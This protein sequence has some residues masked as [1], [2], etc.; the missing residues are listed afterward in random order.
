MNLP[1]ILFPGPVA[2]TVSSLQLYGE[3]FLRLFFPAFCGTCPVLLGAAE[4]G[5]CPSCLARLRESRFSLDE[6]ILSR[7]FQSLDQGWAAYPYEFPVKDLIG[8]VKFSGKRSLLK[9]FRE[10]LRTL[11]RA[12]LAENHYDAL[13]PIPI[14]L[15]KLLER[16]YN[17]SELIAALIRREVSIPV[18]TRTLRKHHRTPS[19]G[20]LSREERKTNLH[21]AFHVFKA[22]KVR[23][24]A[25]LLVDD[26]FTTGA[27]AEEAAAVL[28][29]SGA[30][31]VD[32]FAVAR[33][34]LHQ[35][36]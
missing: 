12:L 17:Q 5:L 35:G 13:I 31:R 28:K 27:T 36:S 33:T 25:L 14:D 2:G 30:R 23:G 26:I 10:D 4:R 1:S 29:Q 21:G 9:I 3:A 22:E 7:K 34:K 16:E 8:A 19:Q 6:A 24:K 32:L 20:S 18:W 15:F 11:V